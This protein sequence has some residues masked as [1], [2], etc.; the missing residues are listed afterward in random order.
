MDI[1][2]KL[3]QA[4]TEAGLTQEAVAEQIG[5]TRQTVSNWETSKSAAI[6]RIASRREAA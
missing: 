1:G 3:R 4:R 2:N 5:I 6:R